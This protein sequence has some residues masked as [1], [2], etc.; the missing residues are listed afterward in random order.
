MGDVFS[1]PV[2]SASRKGEDLGQAF[3][4]VLKLQKSLGVNC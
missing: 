1:M 2:L 3:I 4:I